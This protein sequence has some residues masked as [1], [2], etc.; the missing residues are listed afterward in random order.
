VE[1]LRDIDLKVGA[2]G[3]VAVNGANGAGKSTLLGTIAGV[4]PP[5]AGTI[6]LDARSLAGLPPEAIVRLGISLVPERR[7]IFDTP[8]VRDNLLLGAYHRYCATARRRAPTSPGHRRSSRHWPPCS[9]GWAGPSAAGNSR[10]W[11]SAAE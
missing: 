2:S 6:F 7:Q 1:V 3:I 11:P 10:C 5:C 9:A 4:Y 8:T